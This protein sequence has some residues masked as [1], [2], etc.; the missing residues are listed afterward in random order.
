MPGGQ[1]TRQRDH[2]QVYCPDRKMICREIF[3]SGAIVRIELTTH[4]LQKSFLYSPN[5][6]GFS[7]AI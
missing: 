4:G 2:S 3:G 6:S 1:R 5:S 7:K